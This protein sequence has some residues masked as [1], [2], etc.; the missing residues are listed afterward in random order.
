MNLISWLI[1]AALLALVALVVKGMWRDRKKRT[2]ACCGDCDSGG[3]DSAGGAAAFSGTDCMRY[4]R[5]GAALICV[6]PQ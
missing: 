1:A 2:A 4:R 6:P 5:T 3:S